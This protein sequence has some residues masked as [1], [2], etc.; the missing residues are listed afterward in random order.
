MPKQLFLPFDITHRGGVEVSLFLNVDSD[1]PRVDSR[2]PRIALVFSLGAEFLKCLGH[3][4]IQ[5]IRKAG[6]CDLGDQLAVLSDLNTVSGAYP[7]EGFL[8]FPCLRH[9]HP[10]PRTHVP[11]PCGLLHYQHPRPRGVGSLRNEVGLPNHF[12]LWF[13][14]MPARS[15]LPVAEEV[16]LGTVL[17]CLCFQSE[18][19]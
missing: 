9:K 14:R 2:P 15:P 11:L 6:D 16:S 12:K 17:G 8:P 19:Q 13:I 18:H 7:T 1:I 4:Y 10:N 3:P 5:H